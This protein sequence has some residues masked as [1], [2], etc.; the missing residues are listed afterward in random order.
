MLYIIFYFHKMYSKYNFIWNSKVGHISY[1][2]EIADKNR[3][4][5]NFSPLRDVQRQLEFALRTVSNLI[6]YVQH[7]TH[8]CHLFR[9]TH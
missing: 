7:R 2:S 8:I 1:S 9:Q 6:P 5:S 4:F 3:D